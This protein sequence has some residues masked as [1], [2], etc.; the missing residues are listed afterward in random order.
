MRGASKIEVTA[1]ATASDR[2]LVTA[3]EFN[4]AIGQGA[5]V[6]QAKIEAIIDG[7]SEDVAN[8]CGCAKD[9]VTGAE[10]TLVRETLR[11]TFPKDYC[12]TRTH[13]LLLPW[14]TPITSFTS[15]TEAG[16]ALSLDTDY[17]YVG[18]GILERVSDGY[19]L[20]WSW[21]VVIATYVAGFVPGSIP[22]GIKNQVIDQVKLKY[23][24]AGR[25]PAIMSENMPDVYSATYGV[26]GGRSIGESGLLKSLEQALTRYKVLEV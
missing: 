10:P 19:P 25:D 6:D 21:D 4:A 20:C 2:R 9:T 16:V 5:A 23:F 11:A 12:A 17:R 14:R 3:A 18:G 7:V 1:S 8:Y 13:R 22:P 24:G 15:L 26:A